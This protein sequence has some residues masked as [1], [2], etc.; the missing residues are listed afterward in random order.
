M[1]QRNIIKGKPLNFNFEGES[2][3]VRVTIREDNNG[4]LYYDHTFAI[5]EKG[6]QDSIDFA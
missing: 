5:P 2:K 1:R 4:K 3:K 6:T